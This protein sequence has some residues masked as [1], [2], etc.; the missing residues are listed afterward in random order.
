MGKLLFTTRGDQAANLACTAG[1]GWRASTHRRRAP[2]ASWRQLSASLVR[3][4]LTEGAGGAPSALQ[5]RYRGGVDEWR[6]I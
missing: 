3:H 5:E 2:A 4:K 6:G 1:D